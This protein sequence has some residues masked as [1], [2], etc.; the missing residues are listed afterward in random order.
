LR[1][2]E[3]KRLLRAPGAR[4]TDVCYAAG[5]ND[6]SYF[7]RV[8]RQ[9]LGAS[10]AEWAKQFATRRDLSATGA[11]RVLEITTTLPTLKATPGVIAP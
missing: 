4:V 1:I 5:F 3:A 2:R 10:P 8:F 11:A 9:H 7:G 6:P